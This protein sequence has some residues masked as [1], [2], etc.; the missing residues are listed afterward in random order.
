MVETQKIYNADNLADARIEARLKER[1]PFE[2][3]ENI[4]EAA[5]EAAEEAADG[6]AFTRIIKADNRH[7]NTCLINAKQY[8]RLAFYYLDQGFHED[9]VEAFKRAEEGFENE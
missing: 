7:K 4:K 3:E 8:F 6:L 2:T 5:C 9:I 1:G